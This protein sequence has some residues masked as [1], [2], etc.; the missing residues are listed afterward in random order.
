MNFSQSQHVNQMFCSAAPCF[1]SS[2]LSAG[3][4]FNDSGVKFTPAMN[5]THTLSFHHSTQKT[6]AQLFILSRLAFGRLP[7][8]KECSRLLV[9]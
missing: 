7:V 8:L 5:T 3:G 6:P 4:D 2:L 9:Y 1:H